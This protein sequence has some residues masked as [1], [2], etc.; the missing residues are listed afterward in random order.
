MAES[1]PLP[2]LASRP[3]PNDP[4]APS[5]EEAK[6]HPCD[7]DF[8]GEDFATDGEREIDMSP[9]YEGGPIKGPNFGVHQV[10]GVRFD[11]VPADPNAVGFSYM[12]NLD[13]SEWPEA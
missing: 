3:D 10:S 6:C 4:N 8:D 5:E 7:L 2:P 9:E 12:G 1:P 11:G 13:S